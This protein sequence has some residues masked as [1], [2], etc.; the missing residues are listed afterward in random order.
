M[1]Y[2]QGTSGCR[3][4]IPPKC[5]QRIGVLSP[6]GWSVEMKPAVI[7]DWRSRPVVWNVVKL[8]SLGE[9]AVTA[10]KFVARYG[11]DA[12]QLLAEGGM[13]FRLL[14]CGSIN[15]RGGVGKVSGESA[16]GTF[17]LHMGPLRRDGVY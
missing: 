7:V 5:K 11:A 17:G 12:H 1:G 16:G 4:P 13:A 6:G 8:R 15:G 3:A 10:V 9:T 2:A 14:F